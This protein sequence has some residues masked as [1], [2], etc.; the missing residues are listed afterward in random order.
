MRLLRSW[1]F[2]RGRMAHRP[3]V[4]RRTV[5]HCPASGKPVEVELRLDP[6][7]KPVEVVRCSACAS[8]PPAC[9]QACRA[10]HEAVAGPARA[11]L[12][13]PPGTHVPHDVS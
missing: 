13:L 4:V 8:C 5:L 1:P 3:V 6:D 11:L 12:I 10:L 9:D 7:G 2:R